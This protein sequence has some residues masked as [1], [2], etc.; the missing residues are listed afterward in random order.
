MPNK[1]NSHS[2]YTIWL[3]LALILLLASLVVA[4]ID[5]HNQTLADKAKAE[6]LAKQKEYNCL[7]EA[8]WYEARS[9]SKEGI[10]AVIAVI[11]NRTHSKG[12]P[13]S[14]CS[15]IQQYKQFSYTALNKPSK[16]VLEANLKASEAK[17]YL[18]IRTEVENALEQGYVPSLPAKVLWYAKSNVKNHWTIK[19]HKYATIGK[20]TFYY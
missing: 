19:K 2:K 16:A 14:Y 13:S 1:V 7:F 18:M 20:H 10:R 9:E 15:V 12:Y 8:V 3:L 17:V 6:A 5:E 11:H 4:V